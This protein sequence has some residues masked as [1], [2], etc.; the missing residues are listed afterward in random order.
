MT[1]TLQSNGGEGRGKGGVTQSKLEVFS[2]DSCENDKKSDPRSALPIGSN[3]LKKSLVLRV[4]GS[5][6]PRD[7]ERPHCMFL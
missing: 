7:S 5:L 3:D 6:V 2:L 4:L 1:S